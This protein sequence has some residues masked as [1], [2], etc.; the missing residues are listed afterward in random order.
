MRMWQ[1]AILVVVRE[2]VNLPVF[3]PQRSPFHTEPGLGHVIY[4]HLGDIMMF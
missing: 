1:I 3:T 4:S 2:S